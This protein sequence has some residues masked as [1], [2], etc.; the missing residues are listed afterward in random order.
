MASQSD[1]RVDLVQQLA[2]LASEVFGSA[3]SAD[4]PLMSAGL[5]SIGVTELTTRMASRL[6]TELP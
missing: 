4:A 5:D 2:G 1:S 6:V 3:I